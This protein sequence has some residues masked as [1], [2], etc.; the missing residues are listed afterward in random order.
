MP[1]SAKHDIS[2]PIPKS[3]KITP[4]Q[5]QVLEN[6]QRAEKHFNRIKEEVGNALGCVNEFIVLTEVIDVVKALLCAIDAIDEGHDATKNHWRRRKARESVLDSLWKDAYN[7]H[8]MR[9]NTAKRKP[10]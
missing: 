5:R 3:A 9:S 8:E 7:L 1:K 4:E 6:H 10:R 2:K